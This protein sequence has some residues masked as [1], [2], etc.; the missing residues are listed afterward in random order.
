MFLFILGILVFLLLL[1]GADEAIQ[2]DKGY[3][4][5]QRGGPVP[6]QDQISDV[7]VNGSATKLGMA[8]THF[9]ETYP[10]I[11]PAVTTDLS[12]AGIALDIQ[13]LAEIQKVDPDWDLDDV[14]P[15][16]QQLIIAKKGSALLVAVFLEVTAGPVAVVKGDFLALGTEAGK[17]RKFL[18]TDAAAATDSFREVVGT[19]V[20]ADAGSTSDDHVVIMRLDV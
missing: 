11:A 6:R 14:V 9:G 17:L 3:Q 16:N 10:D 20:E 2:V 1:V 12:F 13:N 5:I 15:D 4:S 18:Y 8:V 7:R 19:V